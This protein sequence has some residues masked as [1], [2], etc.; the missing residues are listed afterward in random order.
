MGQ[1]GWTG[2]QHWWGGMGR[3]EEKTVKDAVICQPSQGH[4]QQQGAK[5]HQNSHGQEIIKE[6][7]S[8]D[9][10]PLV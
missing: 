7:G 4:Q 2:G 9:Q 8:K 3:K 10:G 5:H 6:V 1:V